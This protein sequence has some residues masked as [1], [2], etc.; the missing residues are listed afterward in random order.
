MDDIK[1]LKNLN[2]LHV[3]DD[4]AQ[5]RLFEKTLESFFSRIYHA[6]SG[7]RAFEML[8]GLA[9]HVVFLDI[10]MP[11]MDGLTIAAGIRENDPDIPLVVMTAYQDVSELRRAA[12]LSLTDYLVK[13]VSLETLEDV[14]K[15]CLDQL[16]LRGRLRLAI[17]NDAYYDPSGKCVH[18]PD[19]RHLRLSR[20]E[21]SFLELLLKRP[22]SLVPIDRIENVV[23][24]GDMSFA[25]LRNMVLR[26]RNKLGPAHR[27]EC[28]K[29]IGYTWQATAGS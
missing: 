25:A 11:D 20:R 19:G 5:A 21:S 4:L 24:D 26:L 17:G 13:P 27:I 22:G 23:Y 29:E 10:R 15:K 18:F 14:L 1:L 3:E 8:E 6:V 9:I 2:V 12:A 7:V 28:V 16:N